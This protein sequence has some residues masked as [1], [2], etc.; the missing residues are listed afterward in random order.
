MVTI[1]ESIL[2]TEKRNK[3]DNIGVIEGK[4]VLKRTVG[5]K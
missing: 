1:E 4:K 2:H 3:Q 5:H